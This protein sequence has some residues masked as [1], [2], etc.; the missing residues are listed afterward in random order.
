MGDCVDLNAQSGYF[1][2]VDGLEDDD[3]LAARC[4]TRSIRGQV[5]QSSLRSSRLFEISRQPSRLAKKALVL[6][7]TIALNFDVVLICL[8]RSERVVETS[9]RDRRSKEH[10]SQR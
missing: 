7:S 1:P 2:F 4:R 6:R 8:F 10:G 3:V 5:L 9:I